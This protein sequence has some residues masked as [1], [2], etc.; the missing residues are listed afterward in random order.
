M[1]HAL[2]HIHIVKCTNSNCQ[3]DFFF[4]QI[5]HPPLET[6]NVKNEQNLSGKKPFNFQI[7]YNAIIHS[8]LLIIARDMKQKYY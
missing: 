7:I 4:S 6:P 2:I 3:S 8:Q 1:K 5:T